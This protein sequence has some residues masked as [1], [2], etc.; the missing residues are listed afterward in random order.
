[1]STDLC[2]QERLLLNV[3]LSQLNQNLQLLTQ[4]LSKLL[5]AHS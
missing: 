5:F 4:L 3:L 2:L 1:M